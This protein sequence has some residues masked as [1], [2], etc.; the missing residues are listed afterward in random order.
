MYCEFIILF[1]KKKHEDKR[2]KKRFYN[3]TIRSKQIDLEV[4]F[5]Y[6]L[7]SLYTMKRYMKIN[8]HLTIVGGNI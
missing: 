2:Y 6:S 5:C 8:I 3:P 7:C 1:Y 4:R